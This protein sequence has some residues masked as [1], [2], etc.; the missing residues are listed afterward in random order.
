KQ[1]VSEL[2][3]L[4][5]MLYLLTPNVEEVKLLTE[6]H[7]EYKAAASI[8]TC[9]PVLLTGGLSSMNKEDDILLYENKEV[10][11]QN[12]VPTIHDKHGTGCILSSAITANLA[13]GLP[14][15]KACRKAKT[16]IEKIANNNTNRLAYHN[17]TTK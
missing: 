10:F 3:K 15:E 14:L 17:D 6:I 9:C 16:Y 11:I 5:S 2:K 12:G 4:Y 8:K 1:E 13:H 7:D